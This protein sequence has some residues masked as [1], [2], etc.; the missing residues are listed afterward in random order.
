MSAREA[1][2]SAVRTTTG[3]FTFGTSPAGAS[4]GPEPPVDGPGVDCDYFQLRVCGHPACRVASLENLKV[5]TIWEGSYDHRTPSS[6]LKRV[7][8]AYVWLRASMVTAFSRR[9]RSDQ[10]SPNTSWMAS[11]SPCST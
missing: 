7:T 5:K 4:D 2:A 9:R 10:P 6:G 1:P 8:A 11:I 3:H